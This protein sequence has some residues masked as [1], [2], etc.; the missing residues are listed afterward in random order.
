ML[1]LN[2]VLEVKFN[3][4]E[5]TKQSVR[6]LIAYQK[7]YHPIVTQQMISENLNQLAFTR[8]DPIFVNYQKELYEKLITDTQVRL[9]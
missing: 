9:E 4:V 1:T 3:Q 2:D 7:F 6:G 8:K 5:D